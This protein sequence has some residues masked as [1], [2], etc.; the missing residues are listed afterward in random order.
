M[1]AALDHYIAHAS[2]LELI[3]WDFLGAVFIGL[4]PFAPLW[5][6]E[7]VRAYRAAR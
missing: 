2:T 5:I 4:G 6:A 3:G 7:H 1:L